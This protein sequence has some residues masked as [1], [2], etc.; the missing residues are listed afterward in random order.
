MQQK[1]N[2]RKFKILWATVGLLLIFALLFIPTKAY[3]SD[4]LKITAGFYGGPYYEVG[5]YSSSRMTDLASSNINTYSGVDSG[6]FVRVCYG[7]GP[8][9]QTLISD[10]NI[11]LESV[12]YLHMQTADGYGESVTTFTANQLLNPKYFLPELARKMPE[13]GIVSDFSFSK[14]GGGAK[15]VP[16]ILAI[17]CTEFSRSE[18]QRV[19]T[20]GEY[21][22]YSY[23]DLPTDYQYRL[24]FGQADDGG[25][26]VITSGK[27]IHG[28]EIQLSGSPGLE[29]KKTLVSGEAKKKGSKYKLVCNVNL[30]DSYNY[31]SADA[32]ASLKKQVLANIRVSGYDKSVIKVS[33]LDA[34]NMLKDGN[35]QVEILGKGK[36]SIQFSYAR[37]DYD[38]QTTAS[39]GVG[40]AGIESGGSGGEDDS[41][42]GDNNGKNNGKGAS[43]SGGNGGTVGLKIVDKKTA[44]ALAKAENN[45]SKNS[46]D[47]ASSG[48]QWVAFDPENTVVDF[49][50]EGNPLKGITVAVSLLLLIGGI[51]GEV[52]FFRR[53]IG[54]GTI[55]DKILGRKG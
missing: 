18:A 45:A 49:S 28:I 37:D 20:E 9:L 4:G 47:D 10:C 53:S 51:T 22:Q 32:I 2:Q 34:Q 1:M 46:N 23:N 19:N 50:T 16:T 44:G 39:A 29:I 7:W 55:I 14:Y 25:E 40:L 21:S 27:W 48:N 35:C 17:G 12:K 5:N 52:L 41:K 33:G 42:N 3:A 6:G 54:M 30:P 8:S 26:N 31:L 13:N 24:I 43:K 15:Q 36:T 11:D 38:G